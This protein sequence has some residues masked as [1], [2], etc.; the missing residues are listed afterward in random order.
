MIAHNIIMHDLDLYNNS[1]IIPDITSFCFIA[2]IEL[3]DSTEHSHNYVQY[4]QKA[5]N[6]S[7]NEILSFLT[8]IHLIFA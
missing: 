6:L 1:L 2:I 4:K 8:Y 7:R 5:Q 3:V